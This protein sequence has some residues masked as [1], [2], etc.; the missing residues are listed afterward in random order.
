MLKGQEEMF[1]NGRAKCAWGK[2]RGVLGR[3]ELPGTTRKLQVEGGVGIRCSGD[4]WE[5]PCYAG[6]KMDTSLAGH[7]EARKELSSGTPAG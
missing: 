2:S 5:L 6:A 7:C 3:W 1:I 4:V